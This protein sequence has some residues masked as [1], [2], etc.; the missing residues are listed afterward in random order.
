MVSTMVENSDMPSDTESGNQTTIDREWGKLNRAR[1]V[2]YLTKR[3]KGA[4]TIFW[5]AQPPPRQYQVLHLLI[6]WKIG[7]RHQMTTHRQLEQNDAK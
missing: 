7:V 4:R 3:T 6:G 2:V 5:K 1:K